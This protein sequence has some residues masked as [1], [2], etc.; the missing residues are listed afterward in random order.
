M[1]SKQK[2][3]KKSKRG[4]KFKKTQSNVIIAKRCLKQKNNQTYT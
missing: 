1:R 2:S 4:G 3:K